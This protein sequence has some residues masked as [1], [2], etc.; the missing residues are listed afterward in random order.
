MVQSPEF[1]LKIFSLF[2]RIEDHC[3]Y[4]HVIIA[5]IL[6]KTQSL[7]Y[8]LSSESVSGSIRNAP[9]ASSPCF[10]LN[11]LFE[12]VMGTRRDVDR[13]NE[14][15]KM[16]QMILLI[17]KKRHKRYLAYQHKVDLEVISP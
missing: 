15:K 2:F 5:L 11:T 6:Q 17:D 8:Y 7:V 10:A 9:V 16:F 12:S 4:S 14:M 1:G 3:K 13:L